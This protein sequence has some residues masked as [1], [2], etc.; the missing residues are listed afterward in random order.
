[1][2]D[3]QYTLK[4]GAPWC[5]DY[6]VGKPRKKKPSKKEERLMRMKERM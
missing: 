4:I 5:K 3:P 2:E 1:M 6:K